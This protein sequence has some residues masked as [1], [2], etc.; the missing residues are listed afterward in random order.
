MDGLEVQEALQ[1]KGV[2][3]PVIIM[4]GHGDVSLQFG[5]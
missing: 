5:R 1:A 2:S 4:T 3:L